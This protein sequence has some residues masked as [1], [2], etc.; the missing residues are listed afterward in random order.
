[1]AFHEEGRQFGEDTVLLHTAVQIS[2]LFFAISSHVPVVF[3]AYVS[4]HV[5]ASYTF[6]HIAR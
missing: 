3:I 1:M 4:A 5:Q 6:V 2:V